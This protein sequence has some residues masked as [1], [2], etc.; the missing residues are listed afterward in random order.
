VAAEVRSLARRSAAAAKEISGLITN[1]N[2]TVETGAQCVNQAGQTMQE[3]VVSIDRVKGASSPRS[4]QRL[5]TRR[6]K[7]SRFRGAATSLRD[8]AHAL[9][10]PGKTLR[11]SGN[12]Y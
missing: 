5:H 6:R 1:S 9:A 4:R 11:V 7:S 8:R 12:E 10:E 2:S 3:I